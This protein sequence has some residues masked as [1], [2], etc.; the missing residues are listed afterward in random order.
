MDRKMK[1]VTMWAEVFID[2]GMIRGIDRGAPQLQRTRKISRDAVKAVNAHFGPI[3]RVARIEI[4]EV[5]RA[6]E[7]T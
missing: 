6:R 7:A 3:C 1:T 2:D 5:R 4:R